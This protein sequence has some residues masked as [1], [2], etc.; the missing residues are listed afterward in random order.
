MIA[1]E[2]AANIT[3]RKNI[4]P[5]NV[6]PGICENIAGIVINRSEGPAPASNP[7]A[8]A[9]GI[10]M[11]PAIRAAIVSRKQ[12]CTTLSNIFTSSPR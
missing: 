9:A 12:V 10:I 1:D 7:K 11:N 8:K 2:R 3:L 4:P 6:P 5:R